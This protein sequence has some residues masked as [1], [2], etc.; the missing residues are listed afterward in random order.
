MGMKRRERSVIVILF[1]VVLLVTTI[2]N[3]PVAEAASVKGINN[4]AVFI[5]QK[6]NY[7]CTLAS[8]AMLLRRTKITQGQ[9]SWSSITESKLR[10]KIWLEGTGLSSNFTYSGITVKHTNINSNRKSTY[11]SLLKKHPEGVVAYNYGR[12]GQYHAILLTDYDAKTDTFYCADPAPGR[13]KGRIP[14]SKSSIKGSTQNQ[15]INN[16][17]RCWY[18]TKKTNGSE[19]AT[20][21]KKIKSIAVIKKPKKTTYKVGQK[22]NTAGLKIRVTYSDGTKKDITKGFVVSPKKG[23]ILSKKGTRTITVAYTENKVK[24]KTTFKV[25]VKKASLR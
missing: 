2:I 18:V 12:G 13:A 21:K 24:K 15:K 17:R 22:L 20:K 9:T 1:T 4:S 6:T 19:E 3:T 14:L 25:Y 10:K 23:S 16:L 11:I 7:T 5:K 8:T